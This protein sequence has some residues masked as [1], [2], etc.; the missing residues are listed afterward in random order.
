MVISVIIILLILQR[1]VVPRINGK[2]ALFII[3]IVFFGLGIYYFVEQLD[4]K[5][6]VLMIVGL[7]VG[8]VVFLLAGITN[9]DEIREEDPQKNE[10]RLF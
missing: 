6:G 9:K 8:S 5:I 3:P 4:K 1:F 2:W 7:L 10:E